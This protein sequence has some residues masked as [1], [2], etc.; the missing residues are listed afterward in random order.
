MPGSR[1]SRVA[2]TSSQLQS[3]LKL[4]GSC[5]ETVH[6]SR[7]FGGQPRCGLPPICTRT[8][9]LV[10]P[11]LFVRNLSKVCLFLAAAC[12]LTLHSDSSDAVSVPP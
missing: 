2:G 1:S 8:E 6:Q 5:A 11:W 12:F 7:G 10:P 9:G 3:A 4:G